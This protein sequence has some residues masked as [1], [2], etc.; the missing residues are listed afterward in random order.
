MR[1][2]AGELGQ[3][4]EAALR[5]GGRIALVGAEDRADEGVIEVAYVVVNPW[6]ASLMEWTVVLEG[7]RPRLRSMAALDFAVGRFEREIADQFG[8]SL[9]GHP[10]PARLVKHAHWPE[11]YHPL[12]RGATGTPWLLTDEAEYKFLEVE[13]DAVYEIGVGPVHAGIIEP[14]HFRFSAVGESIITMK[15]RLWFVHR[16]IE[17]LAQGLRFGEAIELAEKVSGDTSV[18]HGLAMATAIEDAVGIEVDIA[19]GAIRELLLS[20]ER[21]YNLVND[22]GAI[23]NDVGFSIV[24]AF[25]SVQREYLMRENRR[26]TGHRLLRGAVRLGGAQLQHRPNGQFFLDRLSE[27]EKIIDILTSNVMVMDRLR[28]IGTLATSDARAIGC[29][30]YVAQASGV[31]PREV[32]AP[33]GA[34]GVLNETAGRGQLAIASNAYLQTGDVAARL[35][36]RIHQL[37]ETLVR[38]KEVSAW[39]VDMPGS[40][41]GLTGGSGWGRA[42]G[43]GCVEGWRGRLTHRVV[44]QNGRIVR[45]K[46]VDPSFF[47]WPAVSISLRGAVVADFPLINK[48]FNLSYAGNDL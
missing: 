25:T 35:D 42:S 15:A 30:G 47:N 3:V 28:G 2:S 14:G 26:L 1:V 36:V 19:S 39:V 32:S 29:V 37:R 21:A 8:V 41:A 22:I 7:R 11:E 13:G 23:A 33:G 46:I 45:A 10:Q 43:I 24:Q 20:L 16:G 48:S 18:G 9:V 6:S 40:R 5:D 34:R 17:K 4:L 27:V 44:V 31:P 38:L 12:R